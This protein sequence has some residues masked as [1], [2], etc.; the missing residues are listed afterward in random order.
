LLADD[1]EVFRFAVRRMLEHG[2]HDVIEARDGSEAV[3]IY[4]NEPT[5]IVVCDMFMPGKD[6]IE[7]ILAL[8]QISPHVCIIAVS[9]GGLNGQIDILPVA[10]RLGAREVL[11]KPFDTA[12][13]L[14]AVERV[15]G[16]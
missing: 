9:S 11:Q 15:S 4:R 6:G 8:R 16:G 7:T 10:M 5:D 14:A 3:R 2:G 13:I 12:H 1:D